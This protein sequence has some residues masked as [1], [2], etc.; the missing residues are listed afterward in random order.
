MENLT[1]LAGGFHAAMTTIA[2]N[3]S[4]LCMPLME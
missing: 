4:R 2:N 3:Q 1:Q